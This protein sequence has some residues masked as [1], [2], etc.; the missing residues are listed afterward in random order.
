MSLWSASSRVERCSFKIGVTID[1][2]NHLHLN[3]SSYCNYLRSL[4]P[5]LQRPSLCLSPSREGTYWLAAHVRT[6]WA[7]LMHPNTRDLRRSTTH[8]GRPWQ[9]RQTWRPFPGLHQY[10]FFGGAV[11]TF[12]LQ[13]YKRRLA[14][15][16]SPISCFEVTEFHYIKHRWVGPNG[17]ERSFKWEFLLDRSAWFMVVVS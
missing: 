6:Y 8:H 14:C 11:V 2:I 1:V 12:I 4:P 5:S 16:K 3:P 15:I 10:H 9:P 7:Q 17:T 13:Q